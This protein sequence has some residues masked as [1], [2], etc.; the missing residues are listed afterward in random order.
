MKQIKSWLDPVQTYSGD[1]YEVAVGFFATATV[2]DETYELLKTNE[3]FQQHVAEQ[4]V[5]VIDI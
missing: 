5:D 3:V 4:H 1:G 2:S